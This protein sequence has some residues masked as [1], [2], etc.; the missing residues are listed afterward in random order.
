MVS[1]W[2][3]ED[4]EL[5]AH[6]RGPSICFGLIPQRFKDL[7]AVLPRVSTISGWLM[8]CV[9]VVVELQLK[10]LPLQ[11]IGPTKHQTPCLGRLEVNETTA[12]SGIWDHDTV[13][14]IKP[15]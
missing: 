13:D 10:D 5:R 2:V 3:C 15:A 12:L 11:Y 7:L 14:D 4:S 6:T 8:L 9:F 1:E